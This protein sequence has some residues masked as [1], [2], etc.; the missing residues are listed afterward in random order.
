MTS[1]A[2]RAFLAFFIWCKARYTSSSSAVLP[3]DWVKVR[4]FS[5]SS[6]LVVN[7]ITRSARSL[8]STRKNSSSGLAVLKN[9]ATAWRA[10]SSLFPMLPLQSKTMPTDKGASSLENCEICCS[11]LSSSDD[12]QRQGSILAGELRDL[13]LGLVL[14]EAE[15]LLFQPRDKPVE[16]IGDGDRDQHQRGIHTNVSLRQNLGGHRRLG[17]RNDGNL[18]TRTRLFIGFAISVSI[19]KG[20]GNP[21]KGNDAGHHQHAAK[22]Q[23]CHSFPVF[24]SSMSV[25]QQFRGRIACAP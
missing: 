19:G 3:L 2:L 11:V 6:R 7:L 12:A 1:R 16:R 13:L 18:R 8:N 17:A 4:R 14:E 9:W 21:E 20:R 25:A 22:S 23:A 15:V 24:L 5:I 10:F